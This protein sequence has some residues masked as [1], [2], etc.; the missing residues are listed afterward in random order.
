MILNALIFL[1][2]ILHLF[3]IYSLF[4]TIQIYFLHLYTFKYNPEFAFGDFLGIAK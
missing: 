1:K 4:L 2:I 3:Y